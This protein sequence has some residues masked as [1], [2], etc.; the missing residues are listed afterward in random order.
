MSKVGEALAEE[1]KKAGVDVTEYMS[2]EMV[3][4]Y[5]KL[6]RTFFHD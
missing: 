2:D 4:D 3:K 6:P 1:K 5:R